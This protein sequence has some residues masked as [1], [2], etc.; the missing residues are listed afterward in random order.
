MS[1]KPATNSA[2]AAQETPEECIQHHVDIM[3][4]VGVDK[5]VALKKAQE[6]CAAGDTMKA[7]PTDTPASWM[8]M[9]AADRAA[10]MAHAN[11]LMASGTSKATAMAMATAAMK[12]KMAGGK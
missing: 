8:N 12:S 1:N 4:S 5:A 2:M 6:V 3:V 10:C 9:S 7:A 11:R